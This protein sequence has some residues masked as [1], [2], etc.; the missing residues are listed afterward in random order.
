[1]DAQ[2]CTMVGALMCT[3]VHYYTMVVIQTVV[4]YC[5]VVVD[6]TVVQYYTMAAKHFYTTVVA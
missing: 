4:H 1:M 3:Y 5:I 2:Y 6:E